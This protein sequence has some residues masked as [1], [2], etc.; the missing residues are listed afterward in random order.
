MEKQWKQALELARDQLSD[1]A[2]N[3]FVRQLIFD[4]VDGPTLKLKIAS[5][6]FKATIVQRYVPLLEQLVEQTFGQHLII[7]IQVDPSVGA[8]KKAS[9]DTDTT[10]EPQEDFMPP[11]IY[12]RYDQ[13][14]QAGLNPNYTMEN[15]V[16]GLSNN[17]AY[18]AASAVIQNPHTTYN[19]LFIYGGTG[20]GK[21]HLMQAIGNALLKKDPTIKIIYCS[22]EKFT[23]DLV[24]SIQT[25]KTAEFRAKYRSCNV[26]LIDDV[27]FI[28]GRDS[29]QEEFFH[30]YNELHSKNTQVVLT[31]DRPP[32]ELQKLEPRLSSRFQ[33]G[34]MVDVQTPD[35]DTRVAILKNKCQ[36]RG[37][38]VPDDCLNLIA[39]YTPYNARELEG[40]LIQILETAKLSNIPLTMDY[41]RSSLG[42]PQPTVIK[43]DSK[44]I[45]SSINNYFNIKT[46]DLIGPRRNKE[47]V[48]PRQL[49]M[50]LLHE[51]CK[52]PFEKIGEL[53]GGRDHT[54]IMH[55]VDKMRGVINRDREVQRM[56][57]ELK[58]ILG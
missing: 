29:T 49:A 41:V 26:F 47:L 54:T 2:Y 23:N 48:L 27:Q 15:Y 45:I 53:L 24:Q 55:G 36:E 11:A 38:S 5:A 37:D 42:R 13:A 44:K 22:S 16:V 57:I 8:K 32:Y 31:S 18:A 1:S 43:I 25:R 46:A 6:F 34:L 28:A 50:Y 10:T 9:A 20:V 58:Q 12:Q 35:F 30:T 3:G 7:D 14:A 51:E 21:T 4:T 33:A 39:E 40:K 17:L 19:P 56:L 52:V